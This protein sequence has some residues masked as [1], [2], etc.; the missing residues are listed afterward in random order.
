MKLTISGESDEV[1]R[2]LRAM[3][4]VDQYAAVLY[5]LYT[6]LRE[7]Y[8]YVEED[9]R[10]PAEKV[11]E[12]FWDICSEHG[13]DPINGDP[14]TEAKVELSE[15][16]PPKGGDTDTIAVTRYWNG[17][18]IYVHAMDVA[19]RKIG[20][21]H[22][23]LIKLHG[24]DKV[25]EAIDLYAEVLQDDKYFFKYK[26]P[27]WEF[28]TRGLDKFLPE[29]D[30]KTNFLATKIGKDDDKRAE[31]VKKSYDRTQELLREFRKEKRGE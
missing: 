24:V 18:G 12:R 10:D 3:L 27:L 15:P 11:Y 9:N 4:M 8:K 20:K 31:Q 21:K 1:R 28:I 14:P 16:E 5:D 23:D 7:Q 30:P 6:Y 22:R 2:E 25:Y 26:W 13:I 17:K 19:I 29:A